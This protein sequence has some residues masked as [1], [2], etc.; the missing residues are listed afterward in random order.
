MSRTTH[1]IMA[2]INA[3][4]VVAVFFYALHLGYRWEFV[5]VTLAIWMAGVIFGMGFQEHI[6][7]S[8]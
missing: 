4:L 8:K 2:T 7:R 6:R 1:I 3:A 5:F